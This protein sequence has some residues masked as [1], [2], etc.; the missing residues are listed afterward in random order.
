MSIL[1]IEP[2]EEEFIWEWEGKKYPVIM[3]KPK[4]INDCNWSLFAN[5][6]EEDLKK[7]KY[8]KY[9]NVFNDSLNKN[10]DYFLKQTNCGNCFLISSII[11][12][13]NIP[14]FLHELF[15]FENNKEKNYTHNDEYLF[16]YCYIQGVKRIIKIKNTYPIYKIKE[17]RE[18]YLKD[19]YC[20]LEKCSPIIFATS[21][22]GVLMG[23][24]LIKSFVC[25][26]YLD[27]D[28][29]KIFSLENC[30]NNLIN[31]MDLK[32]D[33]NLID[34]KV[35]NYGINNL[36]DLSDLYKKLK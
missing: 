10:G 8:N 14:G 26:A 9:F 24:A 4:E 32:V 34:F 35:L 13:I 27:D 11:S 31:F 36:I 28:T 2:N 23:Q 22:N 18:N 15:F 5:I 33:S 19:Y 25:S 17:D 16:L 12:L 30:L 29:I 7:E 6:K 3:A 20:N 21:K 1:N